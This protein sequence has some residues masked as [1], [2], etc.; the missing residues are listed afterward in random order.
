MKY[1]YIIYVIHYINSYSFY[2]EIKTNLD[3]FI[4]KCFV[5]KYI[6]RQQSKDIRY[7]G[8]LFYVTS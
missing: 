4:K 5:Q 1:L 6:D 8:K 3:I 2:Y 7:S